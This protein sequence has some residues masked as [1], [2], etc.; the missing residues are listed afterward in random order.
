M[1]DGKESVARMSSASAVMLRKIELKE[2]G[3]GN[4]QE[5]VVSRMG[6]KGEPN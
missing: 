1:W 6:L 5:R 3:P 2:A 4:G